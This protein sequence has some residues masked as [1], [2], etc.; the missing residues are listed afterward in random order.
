MGL[1]PPGD[2]RANLKSPDQQ[3]QLTI[4]WTAKL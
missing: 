2:G 3:A 4:E 1:V